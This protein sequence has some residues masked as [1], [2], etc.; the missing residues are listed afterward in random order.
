MAPVTHRLIQATVR[1]I[2]P[3]KI[4]SPAASDWCSSSTSSSSLAA[5]A[6]DAGADTYR[7]VSV[8]VMLQGGYGQ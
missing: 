6:S 1:V 8:T 4:N 7:S 5:F 2:W 3:R